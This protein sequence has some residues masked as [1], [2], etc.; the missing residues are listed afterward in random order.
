M[1]AGIILRRTKR[2]ISFEYSLV[3]VY[4]RLEDRQGAG[5]LLQSLNCHVNLIRVNPIK[6]GINVSPD[7][8]Q[9]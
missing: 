4:D 7:V 1:L 9:F 6:E 8:R 3:R 5:A 2:R